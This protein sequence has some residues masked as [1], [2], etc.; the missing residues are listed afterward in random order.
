MLSIQEVGTQILQDNPKSFYVFGGT[1]Y[2]IKQKYIKKLTEFYGGRCKDV[3]SVQE[4]LDFMSTKHLFLPE[5]SV[6]VVRYDTD[7]ISKL[8]E[9]VANKIKSTKILG[10]IICI[11]EQESHTSKCNKFLGDYTVE[12]NS[13]AKEFIAKYIR[14]DMSEL[15]DEYVQTISQVCDSYAQAQ[16]MGCS[17]SYCKGTYTPETVAKVL[18]PLYVS[19]SS[20]LKIGIASRNFKYI[21]QLLNT[22][23][24]AID[25][26]HY[27]IFSTLLEL[28]KLLGQKYSNSDLQPYVKRWTREDIYNLF[29]ITFKELQKLRSVSSNTYTSCIY[30]LSLLP[31]T[32]IP[33]VE[34]LYG[35]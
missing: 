8:S 23:P 15:S 34:V 29:M 16:M 27:I 35:V 17:L 2:G 31:F 26:I 33:S 12:I 19:D 25:S 20:K 14:N 3:T 18:G 22:N 9:Q 4:I 6:Y 5:D 13:P 7:F 10:T 24:E 11:Y 32:K 28:E 30:I 21:L 1:E